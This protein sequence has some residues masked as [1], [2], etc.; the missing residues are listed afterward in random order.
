MYLDEIHL[1]GAN[2]AA[3]HDFYTQVLEL[4]A[5]E[6]GAER[7]VI[8]AGAT[9]LVFSAVP[10]GAPPYHLAFN[11]PQHQ[12]D[13]AREWLRVRAP[14]VRS[15]AGDDTFYFENWDAHALYFYDPAGNILE[16]IARHSLADPDE[17]AFGAHSLRRVSEVSVVADD[18]LALVEQIGAATGCRPYLG[19]ASDSFT[20]VGDEHGLLIVVRRGRLWF[21][22][23][24][25]AAAPGPLEV[26]FSTAPDGP[27]Q[28]LLG[29]P[30]EV[31]ES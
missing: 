9:R 17:R 31:R 4:L 19:L 28:R 1:A 12:L 14:L 27:R 15:Q 11:I 2:L 5:L 13:A 8:Q 25:I 26:A 22:D 16:L 10:D 30:W 3:L 6:A 23:T 21:P 7:L 18:V 20:A 24:G 29:P